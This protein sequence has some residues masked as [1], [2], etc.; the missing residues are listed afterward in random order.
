MLTKSM[1]QRERTRQREEQK[2]DGVVDSEWGTRYHRKRCVGRNAEPFIGKECL[3]GMEEVV[4][5][6][7]VG[8]SGDLDGVVGQKSFDPIAR[9]GDNDSFART[10]RLWCAGSDGSEKAW[11]IC[12]RNFGCV[13][14]WRMEGAAHAQT[15]IGEAHR[16]TPR[17]DGK[18]PQRCV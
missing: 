9:T 5:G 1:K 14:F 6:R 18:D 7:R 4:F 15:D 3:D 13:A 17:C 8:D 2:E 11:G 16:S 12:K 10:A